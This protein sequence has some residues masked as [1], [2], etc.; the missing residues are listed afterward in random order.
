MTLMNFILA[1]VKAFPVLKV[2]REWSKKRATAVEKD[3][4]SLFKK[5][6]DQYI[7]RQDLRYPF[8]PRI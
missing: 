3:G 8:R 6:L 5:A 1:S 2:V 7:I 4:E